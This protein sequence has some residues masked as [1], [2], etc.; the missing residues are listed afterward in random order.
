MAIDW[1]ESFGE[2]LKTYR[3]VEVAKRSQPRLV[4]GIQQVQTPLHRNSAAS[5]SVAGDAPAQ[6]G[7][8][9][10]KTVFMIGGGLVLAGVAFMA[11]KKR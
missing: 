6:A 5:V 10:Y 3:D 11:L 1:G 9:G 7:P 8:V 4:Q 2:V